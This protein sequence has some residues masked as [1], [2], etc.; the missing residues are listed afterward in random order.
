MN[1]FPLFLSMVLPQDPY[2]IYNK[3][4]KQTKI[5]QSR[6]Q[7]GVRLY[8][9]SIFHHILIPPNL[10]WLSQMDP[11]EWTL[12]MCP[13]SRQWHHRNH[14]RESWYVTD[15]PPHRSSLQ[16][17]WHPTLG[18]KGQKVDVEVRNTYFPKRGEDT[19]KRLEIWLMF[20]MVFVRG[21]SLPS[22]TITLPI[23]G[24]GSMTHPG[25]LV[26]WVELK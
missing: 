7:E 24:V 22:C 23:S 19:V 10:R 9:S 16:E 26:S 3:S 25:H 8:L 20:L 17:W 2:K 1:M 4:T 12:Q 21:G 14:S 5:F 18:R 6:G 13:D 11:L 15:G